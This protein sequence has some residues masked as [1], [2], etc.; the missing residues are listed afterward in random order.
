M[1]PKMNHG[2]QPNVRLRRLTVRRGRTTVLRDVDLTLAAGTLTAIIGPSGSG[3]STLLKSLLGRIRPAGGKVEAP[4]GGPVGYVPQDDALHLRLT[5]DEALHYAAALRLP[6]MSDDERKGRI[7]HLV[8]RLGLA[9]R[10]GLRIGKLS[11]GQRKRVSVAMELLHEPNV[12]ALDEPTSGLDPALEA[13]LMALLTELAAEGRVVV[14]TTHAMNS[15][16]RCDQLVILVDGEIAFAGPPMEAPGWFEAPGLH[17]IFDVIATK[18][19]AAWARH[20][21]SAR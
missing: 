14:T 11:G 5:V 21:R 1:Q 8:E 18:P 3:K 19:G 10:R 7:T 12:L 2:S 17:A 6:D 15:L 13:R 16:H 20:W 9:E 4:E